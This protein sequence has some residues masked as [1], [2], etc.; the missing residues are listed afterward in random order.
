MLPSVRLNMNVLT[1]AGPRIPAGG[2]D[3]IVL[4]EAGGFYSRKYGSWSLTSLFSTNQRRMPN[5]N[6]DHSSI[7]I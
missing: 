5:V 2:S 4:I 7:G 6:A 3:I 1:E